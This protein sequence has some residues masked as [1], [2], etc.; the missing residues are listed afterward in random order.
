MNQDINKEEQYRMNL[1]TIYQSSLKYYAYAN[2]DAGN[3][4][5][6]IHE[7]YIYF[8]ERY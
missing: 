1:N 5:D 6:L 7:T 3:V 4:E 8:L 2:F